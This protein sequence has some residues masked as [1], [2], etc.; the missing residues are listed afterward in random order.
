M[1]DNNAKEHLIG[2]IWYSEVLRVADHESELKIQKFKMA[3]PICL[4]K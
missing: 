2:I 4:T 1:A 3:D